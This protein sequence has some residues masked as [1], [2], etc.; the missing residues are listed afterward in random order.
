MKKTILAV[1]LAACSGA[2]SAQ[3]VVGV[4]ASTTGPGSSLGV[5]VANAV[6]LL[7]KT[8][9]GQ[10]IRYIV[11]DDS[12]DPTTGTRNV[13]KLISE[14]KADVV[15]G[16]T[17]V[18]VAIAQSGVANEAK[19]P[20]LAL[21]PMPVDPAKQ[22]YIFTVP[23]PLSLMVNALLDHM[24]QTGVK[25]LAYMG[26]ADSWGDM[27]YNFALKGAEQ[28]GIEV[29]TNERF[30]RNDTSV[31]SQVLKVV[32]AKPDAIFV[33]GSGTPSALPQIAAI[34]RGYSGPIYHTHGVVSRDFIR[35]AGNAAKKVV[36]TTGPVTV[37]EQLPEDHPL[38]ALG[39][40]FLQKYEGE[41]GTGS[42]NA[43]AA[44]VWDASLIIQA[45]V[46]QALKVAKPGTPEF[47][48]AMRDAI[49]SNKDVRGA[50]A[51]YNMSP[52]DHSGVDERA[53]VLVTVADNEWK[54]L[55]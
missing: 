7:P 48:Q 27:N 5:P 3:I 54:I 22:P 44:Y 33:G 47:R 53:R 32:A 19:T 8:V 12:S 20:I 1:L 26:F 15:I 43:F 25:R 41:H 35:V 38:K 55:D 18:P 37:A 52:S 51:V 36:A 4:S 24:K 23:Q 45:A 28:R 31:N 49:E 13:S 34:D 42:R 2:V 11:L 39:V 9:A 10:T 30:N 40:D 6:P 50:H 46:P 17:T 29:I 14:D 21:A 16:S